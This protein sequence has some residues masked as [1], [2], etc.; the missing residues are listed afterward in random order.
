MTTDRTKRDDAAV[1]LQYEFTAIVREEIG[2]NEGF[3]S[4]I[5]AALVRGLRRR[6]RGQRLGDYYLS[7][8]TGAEREERDAAIRAEFN[9][10]NRDEVCQKYNLKKTQLYEIVGKRT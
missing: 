5:A 7:E 1:A 2:M 9:G 8:Q 4:Q 10:Q 6:F 3:A